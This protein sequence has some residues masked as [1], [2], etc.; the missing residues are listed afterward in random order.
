VIRRSAP[1][2]LKDPVSNK[3]RPKSRNGSQLS[4]AFSKVA[5]RHLGSQRP[6]TKGCGYKAKQILLVQQYST[7]AKSSHI[8]SSNFSVSSK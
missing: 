5:T 2:R 1:C 6:G 8:A 7:T 3:Y 4:L